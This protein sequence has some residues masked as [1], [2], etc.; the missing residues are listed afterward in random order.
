[1][2]SKPSHTSQALEVF[3]Q[4]EDAQRRFKENVSSIW[5]RKVRASEYTEGRS[6]GEG[7]VTNCDCDTATVLEAMSM[8]E[9]LKVPL[10]LIDGAGEFGVPDAAAVESVFAKLAADAE[11]LAV[12]GRVV[13]AGPEGVAECCSPLHGE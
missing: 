9:G 1:M 12:S 3:L 4:D 11:S 7:Q 6:G 13:G 2:P 5:R 8:D 10:V